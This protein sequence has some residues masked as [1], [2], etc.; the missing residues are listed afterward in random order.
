M[1][2][3]VIGFGTDGTERG[4]THFSSFLSADSGLFVYEGLLPF[5]DCALLV[6]GAALL[7]TETASYAEGIVWCSAL[8]LLVCCLCRLGCAWPVGCLLAGLA[9]G[10][11]GIGLVQE[12]SLIHSTAAVGIL[13]LLFRA[14]A[15]ASFAPGRQSRRLQ[16]AGVL[17]VFLTGAAV[18]AFLLVV[19]LPWRDGLL[20]GLLVSFGSTALSDRP[21]RSSR[22][23]LVSAEVRSTLSVHPALALLVAVLLPFFSGKGSSEEIAR[24]FFLSV[25][26]LAPILFLSHKAI[27][28]WLRKVLRNEGGKG[29]F[30]AVL[31]L[32]SG[33]VLLSHTVGLGLG[34]GVFLAG[35]LLHRSERGYQSLA[36]AIP[37]DLALRAPFF[38]A[39]GMLF[40]PFFFVGHWPLVLSAVLCLLLIKVL[41][42]HTSRAALGLPAPSPAAALVL[43]PVGELAFFLLY[44]GREASLSPAGPGSTGE[45]L[46]V[47]SSVLSLVLIPLLMIL[48]GAAA[49][50]L[51]RMRH[52]GA[53]PLSEKLQASRGADA[54]ESRPHRSWREE[55]LVVAQHPGRGGPR[56]R[57]VEVEVGAPAA[58]LLIRQL[59]AWLRM[60]YGLAVI[61][62]WRQDVYLA[63]TPISLR[64]EPGDRLVLSGNHT[65]LVQSARLF[66]ASSLDT[67]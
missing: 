31:M 46:L 19:G 37:I 43:L 28:T 38:F 18:T 55:R 59:S 20:I 36:G 24:T 8:L 21:S 47:A 40:D 34:V 10:P 9:A 49:Q 50:V 53:D 60:R 4:V 16:G 25:G 62:V 65:A 54:A 67:Y 27:P 58:D 30:A 17:F 61:A 3:A 22:M 48:K 12:S 15:G 11:H 64:L 26:L 52:P 42:S 32:C 39:L 63:P 66:Q 33:T 6:F 41:A 29:L 7:G 45:Q 5:L 44:A 23:P 35:L 14:G 1:R 2:A 13:L 56:V 57:V 51:Q